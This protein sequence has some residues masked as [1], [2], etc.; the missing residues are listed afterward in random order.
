MTNPLVA[1][2]VTNATAHNAGAFI[3]YGKTSIKKNIQTTDNLPGGDLDLNATQDLGSPVY[4]KNLRNYKAITASYQILNTDEIVAVET[5]GITVTLPVPANY[6]RGRTLL[7]KDESG[8]AG[9]SNITINTYGAD[10]I[11]GAASVTLSD[12]YGLLELYTDG[13]NWYTISQGSSSGGGGSS[14]AYSSQSSNYSATSSD[15]VIGCSVGGITITLPDASTVDAG[16]RITVK[17]EG[18]NAGDSAITIDTDGGNI[19][20]ES[21]TTID[22]GYGSQT[23]VSNETNW[24][25]L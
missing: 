16:K 11:D 22:V 3:S 19:D 17:D 7:I 21:S 6:G 24:F 10:T 9:S 15:D 20:G 1:Q 8:N 13:D 4:T 5:A 2:N 18:G 12:N 23:F 14:T 25:K